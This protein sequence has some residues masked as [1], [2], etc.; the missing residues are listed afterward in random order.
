MLWIRVVYDELIVQESSW[1]I[2]LNKCRIDTIKTRSS[3]SIWCP[4]PQGCMKFNVCGISNEEVA[5]CGRVLRDMKG[6]ARALFSG[7]IAANDADST[8]TGPCL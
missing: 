3:L 4:P 6:V 2:C 5:G 1:W 7:P 8:E